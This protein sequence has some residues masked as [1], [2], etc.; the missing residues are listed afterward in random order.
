MKNYLKKVMALAMMTC[1]LFS[2]CACAAPENNNLPV[3]E[4]EKQEIM[5]E[6]TKND[7]VL[8][9][10]NAEQIFKAEYPEMVQYPVNEDHTYTYEDYEAWMT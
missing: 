6:E 9:G 7:N 8:P 10:K 4:G 3:Q 2:M 5:K 1:L